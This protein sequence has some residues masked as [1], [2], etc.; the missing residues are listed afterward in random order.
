[1][2]LIQAKIQNQIPSLLMDQSAAQSKCTQ[3]NRSPE[4]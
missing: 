1:M 2:Y 4:D 3:I